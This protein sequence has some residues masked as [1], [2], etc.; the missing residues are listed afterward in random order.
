MHAL[1][2]S[3]APPDLAVSTM[4]V[5][6]GALGAAAPGPRER[7]HSDGLAALSDVD[8]VAL[9][10]GHGARGQPVLTQATGV[11]ERT[12]GLVGLTRA[13][14]ALLADAPGLG[15][16]KAYRLAASVEIGRRIQLRAA[17]PREVY[18][19]PDAVAAYFTPRIGRL[20]HE[21]MWVLSLDGRNRCRGSRR[22][23]QGGQHGLVVAARE[24]LRAALG[25]AASGF[26]LVHNHPSGEPT[27]SQADVD[28]T[29]AV[30]AAADVVGVPLLDHVIVT[31]SGA[32]AS[33][34]DAGLIESASS[35]EG[36]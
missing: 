25:D 15:R 33:L 11:L 2:G 30:V 9:V 14:P 19:T 6:C 3:T 17:E 24:I 23:A 21:Q 29:R 26:V 27:P 28:M 35:E 32:Y 36:G 8:L 22:V 10:L 13:G 31:A 20:A 18:G 7:A 5:P 34:L 1:D 4:A 16:A 12:G